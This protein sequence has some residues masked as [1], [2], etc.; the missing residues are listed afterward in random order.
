MCERFAYLTRLDILE[1]LY[2]YDATNVYRTWLP[3][4]NIAPGESAP[5]I[6][7]EHPKTVQLMR[8][9]F[10]PSHVNRRLDIINVRAEGDHNKENDPSYNRAKGIIR[11]PLFRKAIRT[12]RC[13]IFANGFMLGDFK[14][15]TSRKFYFLYPY[16][17]RPITLAGIYDTWQ[18]PHSNALISGFA[19]ITTTANSL[20]Q[21]TGYVRSP[22]I[23]NDNDHWKWLG[24]KNHLAGVT[25]LL[26]PFHPN[27]FTVHEISSKVIDPDVKE[28]NILVPIS[29]PL[30]KRYKIVTT[31]KV[32]LHGMGSSPARERRRKEEDALKHIKTAYNKRNE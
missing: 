9:G 31:Q 10:T 28:P 30:K 7:S 29:K 32:T 11:K 18:D 6:T 4:A 2:R 3:N 25:Q 14:N 12:K 19:I 21:K 13:L 23:I 8:F 24:S 17:K 15:E 27:P 16:D 5:V 22:V 1:A 26:K 20:V